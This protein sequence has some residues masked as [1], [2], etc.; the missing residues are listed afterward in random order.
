MMAGA[1]GLGENDADDGSHNTL[2]PT[3]VGTYSITSYSSWCSTSE[4]VSDDANASEVSDLP[5]IGGDGTDDFESDNVK[6]KTEEFE[7]SH[8][9]GEENQMT[10][11][12]STSTG[13]EKSGIAD[14]GKGHEEN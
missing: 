8:E 3:D 2:D 5:K 11:Q 13:V 12:M 9:D 4:A 6:K 7:T 14:E 10:Y 1:E